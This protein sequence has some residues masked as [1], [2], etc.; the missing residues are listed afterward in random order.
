MK[1]YKYT[2]VGD[3]NTAVRFAFFKDEFEKEI[4]ENEDSGFDISEDEIEEIEIDIPVEYSKEIAKLITAI[5]YDF[6][7][8]H[9]T[10]IKN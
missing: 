1:I 10:E 3:T 8:G 7:I 6:D 2:C 4:Q 5:N 9:Y